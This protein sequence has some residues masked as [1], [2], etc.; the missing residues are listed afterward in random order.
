M[1]IRNKL[2]L[3]FILPIMFIGTLSVLGFLWNKVLLAEVIA[4]SSIKVKTALALQLYNNQQS[5]YVLTYL[6]LHDPKAQ[7]N[8]EDA[9]A[10]LARQM[11][12]YKNSSLTDQ[13]KKYFNT[14]EKQI[15]NSES[16]ESKLFDLAPKTNFQVSRE[17]VQL[18]QQDDADSAEIDTFS[19]K[20]YELAY[21]DEK[22][23]QH[24]VMISNYLFMGMMS[25]L[26]LLG[27]AL[28]VLFANYLVRPIKYLMAT[29]VKLRAGKDVEIQRISKDETGDL[30]D[31]FKDLI[32]ENKTH[33]ADLTLNSWLKE[34]LSEVLK[35]A[36]AESD[37]EKMCN[38]VIV[39]VSELLNAG[40]GAFY[41]V[42]EVE[43]G[44]KFLLLLGTYGYKKRKSISNQF[45]FGEGLIGQAA[46]EAKP[47]LLT[48][49]PEDYIHIAS[50]LGEKRP[51]RIIVLP[52][53]LENRTKG[54][55]E[56]ASFHE[57]AEIQQQFL[58]QIASNLGVVIEAIESRQRAEIA[59]KKVQESAEELQTQQE[60]LR[61][62][63]EELEEK[64]HI[65]QQS[66]EELKTQSEELQASNEEL[67]EKMQAIEQ[68]KKEIEVKNSELEETKGELEKKAKALTAAGK[69]KTEFLSNMSHELRTPL[70]SLLLLSKSFAKN[71]DGNLTAEQIEQANIIYRGGKDLL[72]LI[73]DI[74]DLSK[75]EAGKLNIQ[76]ETANIS[77]IV[78]DLKRQFDSVAKAK[79]LSFEV[80]ITTQ[81]EAMETDA[82]RLKQILRNLISNALK[83]TKEGYVKLIIDSPN[84]AD[85]L[86]NKNI[87][88]DKYLVFKVVDT[89]IGIEKE[90]FQDIFEA[91]QQAYG[92]TD[93]IYGGTGLGLTISRELA[94]LLGGE[95][96][97]ES[98][99]GKGS[100]F[101]VVIPIKLNQS[102][103]PHLS[104]LP[105]LQEPTQ[106][107]SNFAGLSPSSEPI[108][109]KNNRKTIL[110]IESDQ[111]FLKTLVQLTK[112]KGYEC[113]TATNGAT[114]LALAKNEQP[115]GI[116]LSLVLP[117]IDGV[118]VLQKLKE[119]NTT[120]DIP[121][122]VVSSKDPA[123]LSPYLNSINFLE[124]TVKPEAVDHV[125]QSFTNATLADNSRI[126][127]VED[128]LVTQ[129]AICKAA[130]NKNIAIDAV[131][132][133][134]EAWEKL[135]S[136]TF[137]GLVLD[138]KLPDIDGRDLLKMAK[139]KSIFLPPVIIYS[140]KDLSEE[141][142]AELNQYTNKIV[143]K[144]GDSSL[145]R[146]LNECSLFLHSVK[147]NDKQ[148]V[149][150]VKMLPE[151]D[152][153]LRDKA[154]LLV[155]DDMRNV[156]A[157]SIILQH[158]KMNVIVA[159]NGEEALKKLE[160][161]QQQPDIIIMD[162]MMPVLDGYETMKCIRKKEQYKNLPIIAVT[163]KAMPDDKKACIEAGANDY[164]TKPIDDEK[165]LSMMRIWLSSTGKDI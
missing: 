24:K 14:I 159:T 164:I 151:T 79:G 107:Q 156:Y 106:I 45:K 19:N 33:A 149:D 6:M 101:K 93:R 116:I 59:L 91:F 50:G 92:N 49:V 142:Y 86:S 76:I 126:L 47:I 64:T 112:A 136:N 25:V 21:L 121:V 29:I 111:E 128:D 46:L 71:D 7:K 39:K 78:D 40:C 3:S 160:Q 146:L 17:L 97:L 11:Q 134:K 139:E 98:V 52:I 123:F 55:I 104:I 54:V 89:G 35:I 108:P 60:E 103:E 1:K 119:N 90:K 83:F 66:E 124:K 94:K 62:S 158:Q 131:A 58:E 77:D 99:V 67:E 74:L 115:N 114:G 65:L 31:A 84:N 133:G 23:I 157:L 95:I 100:C 5:R 138:L 26:V 41:I 34:H 10:N 22:T 51:N 145:D 147:K 53:I 36:Q 61:T 150:K 18:I 57:I 140:Q 69:Y 148:A 87:Q 82:H 162:I 110:A 73:N 42:K 130:A 155:D 102:L 81:I 85:K 118:A 4:D 154:V 27:A 32:K 2:V 72:E 144:E 38:E 44:D 70:N 127:L 16:V 165:L 125:L 163:A 68:Q 135:Q 141:E 117:D 129:K 15:Q 143:R 75:V 120:K 28:A 132:T 161:M 9:G 56:I 63:N 109:F 80:E 43:N 122:H 113:L 30:A 48:E 96:V 20:L 13:E 8:Y 88:R 37:L 105:D 153:I 137:G 152:N 12:I